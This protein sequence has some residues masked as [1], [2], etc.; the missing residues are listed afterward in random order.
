MKEL[1]KVKKVEEKVKKIPGS[2]DV[3]YK[4]HLWRTVIVYVP[5]SRDEFPYNQI[6]H[7]I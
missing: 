4:G 5:G 2:L 6:I 7:R 3:R 1:E